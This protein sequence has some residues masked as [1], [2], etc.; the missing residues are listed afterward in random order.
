MQIE[1]VG[2]IVTLCTH[3]NDVKRLNIFLLSLIRTLKKR[4]SKDTSACTNG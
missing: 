3:S 2:V 4:M 1:I